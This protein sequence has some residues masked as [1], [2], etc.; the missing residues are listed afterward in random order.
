MKSRILS[1]KSRILEEC[2][3]QGKEN[4]HAIAGMV[5]AASES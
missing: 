2:V 5:R 1:V 4:A 3:M